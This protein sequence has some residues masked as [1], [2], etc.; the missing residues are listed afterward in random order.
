[1]HVAAVV[2]GGLRPVCS[3][4]VKVRQT[5]VELWL[6]VSDQCNVTPVI[7]MFACS[8]VAAAECVILL[9]FLYFAQLM[10]SLQ[11]F[12]LLCTDGSIDKMFDY[13]AHASAIDIGESLTAPDNF[14]V[15]TKHF[16]VHTCTVDAHNLLV[17][18]AQP[19]K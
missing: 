6:A 16:I 9:Y 1:M 15:R 11:E 19:H 8:A 3:D 7:R 5:F 4:T 13:W 10:Q 12:L 17:L 18:C 14:Q 2:F